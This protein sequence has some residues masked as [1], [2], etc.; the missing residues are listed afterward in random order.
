M[1]EKLVTDEMRK[2]SDAEWED[3]RDDLEWGLSMA[4]GLSWK[5]VEL[6]KE[7]TAEDERRANLKA[8]T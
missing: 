8:T 4:Y 6:E 7:I 5:R 2:L 3:V 1:K